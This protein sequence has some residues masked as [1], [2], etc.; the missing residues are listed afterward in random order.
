MTSSLGFVRK[1]LLEAK[2]SYLHLN[3]PIRSD[4]TFAVNPQ[5]EGFLVVKACSA[6]LVLR[7]T[8]RSMSCTCN[9]RAL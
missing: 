3:R 1:L 5:T 2:T 6:A 7:V 9:S 8:V 4:K